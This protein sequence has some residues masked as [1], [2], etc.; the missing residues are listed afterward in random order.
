MAFSPRGVLCAWGRR[1][2][3][4]ADSS[5]ALSAL[6]D[7]TRASP[8][9]GRQGWWAPSWCRPSPSEQNWPATSS[10]PGVFLS[11]WEVYPCL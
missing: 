11:M 3:P 8:S 6:E 1:R 4:T 2:E 5:F 7:E 9:A 10:G